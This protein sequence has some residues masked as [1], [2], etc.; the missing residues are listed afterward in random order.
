MPLNRNQ[1][2][3]ILVAFQTELENADWYKAVQPYIKATL[4]Y[5]STVRG[6]NRE[7]SDIDMLLIVPLEIEEKYTK[8]EYTYGFNGHQINIV[9][10]SI[11]RLRLIAAA[12]KDSSQQEVFRDAVLIYQADNEVKK[13]LNTI[14]SKS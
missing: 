4:L 12:D 11:E 6:T 1:A 7:D 5:G 3:D 10:R 8:G 2:V 9:L 13:L 14:N